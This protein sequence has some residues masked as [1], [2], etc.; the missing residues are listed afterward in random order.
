[1]H[2]FSAFAAFRVVETDPR[3]CRP[4]RPEGGGISAYSTAL[5]GPTGVEP[6]ERHTI[7][8]GVYF[9]AKV[10]FVLPGVTV[11]GAVFGV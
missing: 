3:G 2:H 5:M 9:G 7:D 4:G 8:Q 10:G 1:M 11:I 6:A